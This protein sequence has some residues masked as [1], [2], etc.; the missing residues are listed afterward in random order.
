MTADPRPLRLGSR[1]SP[2]ALVQAELVRR[3]ILDRFPDREVELVVVSTEGDDDASRPLDAFGG[4][5][6]FVKAIEER[7]LAGDIDVAVHSAKDLAVED[8]DDLELVAFL[9]REE[10]HDVLVRRYSGIGLERPGDGFRVATDSSRRRTQLADAWP[11]AE[12]V[13][14]RGNIETRLGK[15]TAGAADGLVLA[16]AGLR[17][18]EL[19]PEGAEPIPVSMCI[20]APGQGAIVAQCRMDDPVATELRILNHLQ[21]ALAVQTERDMAAA[22]GAGCAMPLGV[23]VEFRSGETRL[24]AAFHDG[25]ELHRVSARSLAGAP[26]E[27]V[28]QAIADLRDMGVRW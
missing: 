11:G 27:A 17:R 26:H 12:F 14:V 13:H 4:Q 24:I 22:L 28:E 2:L 25:Q 23:Y 20:P 10:P 5:G 6:V 15:L 7:L 16:A 9:P 1:G 18:L 3:A 8:A 21:T 19:E